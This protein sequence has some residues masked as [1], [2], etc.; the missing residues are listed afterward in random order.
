MITR[1]IIIFFMLAFKLINSVKATEDLSET[2]DKSSLGSF[3][4]QLEGSADQ[5]VRPPVYLFGT[6]H[7]MPHTLIQED[8]KFLLTKA[9]ILAK[10]IGFSN[11]EKFP[12]LYEFGD[13]SLD[14]LKEKGFLTAVPPQWP[15]KYLSPEYKGMLEEKFNTDLQQAWGLKLEEV[16]PS[17][18]HHCLKSHFEIRIREILEQVPSLT[19]NPNVTNASEVKTEI[20]TID[21]YIKCQ[22]YEKMYDLEDGLIRLETL[23]NLPD[24]ATEKVEVSVKKVEKNLED[25]IELYSHGK[26]KIIEIFH[27]QTKKNEKALLGKTLSEAYLTGNTEELM[28]GVDETTFKRNQLWLP[29][30]ED[31]ICQNSQSSI[32]IMVGAAHLLGEKGLLNLLKAKGFNFTPLTTIKY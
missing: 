19:N 29:K 7:T 28:K 25:L 32:L 22:K 10:E 4:Y 31:I 13:V 24:L 3:L 11:Y 27:E 8:V 30:I 9:Q 16:P 15:S 14:H 21:S 17:I 12:E 2:K 5:S 18:I 20:P 26:N 23:Y 1:K 6:V